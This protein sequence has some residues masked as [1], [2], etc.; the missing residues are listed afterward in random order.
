MK[1]III[2]YNINFS[3]LGKIPKMFIFLYTAFLLPIF[4]KCNVQEGQIFHNSCPWNLMRGGSKQILKSGQQSE[5]SLRCLQS[6]WC[7]CFTF[8]QYGNDEH[9]VCLHFESTSTVEG[10]YKAFKNVHCLKGM[11]YAHLL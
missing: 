3:I 7:D 6:T 9:S 1:H 10:P 4:M 11:Y 8:S 5:C 2:S